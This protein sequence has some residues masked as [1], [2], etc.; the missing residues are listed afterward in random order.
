[1]Q[2]VSFHTGSGQFVD[3]PPISGQTELDRS[4]LAHFLISCVSM[5]P[6]F[7]VSTTEIESAFCLSIRTKADH[8]KTF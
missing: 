1:M 4:V 2:T 6:E 7:T 5:I 3:T 8:H